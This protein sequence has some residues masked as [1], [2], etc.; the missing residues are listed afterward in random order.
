MPDE[1]TTLKDALVT[2]LTDL[3]VRISALQVA[4]KRHHTPLSVGEL[5]TAQNALKKD[6]AKIRERYLELLTLPRQHQ[7]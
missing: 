6:V 4:V 1:L 5:E 3:D 2:V 7:Q